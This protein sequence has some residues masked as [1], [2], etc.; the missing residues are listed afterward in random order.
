M[1]E[2]FARDSKSAEKREYWGKVKDNSIRF[3]FIRPIAEFLIWV[4]PILA[5]CFVLFC[6]V[7][8]CFV[9]AKKRFS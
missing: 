3:M 5:F 6:F 7:L 8:F 9:F 1:F 2:D 4:W